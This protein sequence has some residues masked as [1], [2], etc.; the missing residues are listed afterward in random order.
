M[1]TGLVHYKYYMRGYLAALPV[2][3][4]AAF[5]DVRVGVGYILGY[6]LHRYC[7]ND[8]DIFGSNNAEG[9]LVNEI[10]VLGHF[11]YGISSVYGSMFRR[12]HRSWITHWPVVSTLIRLIFIFFIP[13]VIGDGYGINFIGRGWVW[14]WVGLWAGLSHADGIHLRHDLQ[15]TKE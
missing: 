5:Y 7:D 3:V 10:P 8:W 1:S 12:Y 4:A 9:R 14:F 13:F 15:N 11:L 2:S 6:S